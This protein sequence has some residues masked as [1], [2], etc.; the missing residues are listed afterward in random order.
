VRDD[1]ADATLPNAAAN[2]MPPEDLPE[3]TPQ[4]APEDTPDQD[5]A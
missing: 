3:I 5:S 1:T 2:P 4:D